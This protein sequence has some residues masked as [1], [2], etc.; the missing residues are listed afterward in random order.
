MPVAAHV[1]FSE[2]VP[3]PRQ[4]V[5]QF[6]STG[7][8]PLAPKPSSTL[9]ISIVTPESASAASFPTVTTPGLERRVY[10][11]PQQPVPQ[12]NQ[13]ATQ[14]D[15]V[16]TVDR[17]RF[18]AP[19]SEKS[20][21][22]APVHYDF[23]TQSA[24]KREPGNETAKNPARR[25]PLQWSAGPSSALPPQDLYRD[26]DRHY[27]APSS[28][29]H[30]YLADPNSQS[31]L[32]SSTLGL[33]SQAAQTHGRA[34]S[35]SQ[36]DNSGSNR[37]IDDSQAWFQP[38][39][40]LGDSPGLFQFAEG[41]STSKTQNNILED[42]NDPFDVSDDDAAME[43]YY[44]VAEMDEAIPDAHLKK[45]DL[46]VVVALQAMH[47]QDTQLR[48]FTTF[49]DRPNMLSQYTPSPQASP[50]KDPTTARV[51]CH[52]INVTGPCLSMFER[53]PANPLLIFQGSPVSK[54]QQHI[55]TC[56]YFYT[57]NKP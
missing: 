39:Q 8:Y 28:L 43:D 57:H 3:T 34:Q 1:P 12:P 10:G 35:S 45:N 51:F 15:E 56:K 30:S 7:P 6:T 50:L 41:L 46:G 26:S 42:E 11:W 18:P 53:H 36:W 16:D 24:I 25:A 23:N 5:Q 29:Y 13:K 52:F 44:N 14:L 22:D 38:E 17:S 9:E 2:P 40:Q 32:N 31:T 4:P 55:W 47:R 19:S 49:I 33:Q 54:S 20:P 37:E 21:K 27:L 48:S